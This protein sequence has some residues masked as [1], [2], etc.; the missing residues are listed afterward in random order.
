VFV[1]LLYS[2]S[3][4]MEREYAIDDAG[5]LA[6]VGEKASDGVVNGSWE[7]LLAKDHCGP[8]VPRADLVPRA[9]AK[10]SSCD[11][12]TLLL[13]EGRLR[14][15]IFVDIVESAEDVRRS[16]GRDL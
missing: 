3:P 1:I 4:E 14:V 16:A 6:V 2:V 12:V 11:V 13:Y 10:E 15:A 8:W 9:P 5:E 7:E